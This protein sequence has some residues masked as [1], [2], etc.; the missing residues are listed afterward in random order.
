MKNACCSPYKPSRE[1]K[2]ICQEEFAAHSSVTFL[3]ILHQVEIFS[4]LFDIVLG[5][6]W[7]QT[8][9]FR[10]CNNCHLAILSWVLDYF[11]MFNMRINKWHISNVLCQNPFARKHDVI[12]FRPSCVIELFTPQKHYTAAR[13]RPAFCLNRL[14]FLA[15]VWI[16]LELFIC[17]SHYHFLN[18]VGVLISK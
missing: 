13:G 17:R 10:D 12:P 9:C 5:I 15:K 3:S 14:Q 2:S 1:K 4:H 16:K 11:S 7:L 6:T 8:A 18:D